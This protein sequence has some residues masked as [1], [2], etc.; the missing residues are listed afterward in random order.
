VASIELASD[1][2]LPPRYT[3]EALGL[4]VPSRG[5]FSEQHVR[6]SLD[7]LLKLGVQEVSYV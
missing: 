5:V 7:Q 1:T 6:L 2:C 3:C 4:S